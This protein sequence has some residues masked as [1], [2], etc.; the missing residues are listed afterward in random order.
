MI[1]PAKGINEI[2][3]SPS[4]YVL[5][6][7][8]SSAAIVDPTTVEARDEDGII[9]KV[10]LAKEKNV[11]RSPVTNP[12]SAAGTLKLGPRHQRNQLRRKPSSLRRLKQSH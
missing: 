4:L 2:M 9:R 1:S 11:L 6:S 8:A 7:F 10:S 3:K 12:L 5:D